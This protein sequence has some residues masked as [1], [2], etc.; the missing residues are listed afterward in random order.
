M[1]R[2]SFILPVRDAAP[3]LPAALESLLAQTFA[4]HEVLVHD[5]GSTDESP[6]IVERLAR[7]DRRVRLAG[8]G[9]VG[10]AR[11]LDRLVRAS[12][13]PL[14]ARMDADDRSE[15]RRLAE[16]VALLAARPD[17]DVVGCRV[18]PFADGPVPAGMRRYTEWLNTLVEPEDHRQIG[19]AHV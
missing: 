14:L 5:D 2:V 17:V 19:R 3:T 11:A 10:V 6:R 16:Q 13:S 1:P 18:R 4:D 15:P 12:S 7:R 9:R 8:A